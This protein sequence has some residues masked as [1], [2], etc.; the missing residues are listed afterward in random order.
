MRFELG[1][2]SFG[3]AGRDSEGNDV[4]QAMAVRNVL[5]QIRLAEEVGL[6]FFGVGEHHHEKVPVSSPTSVLNAAAAMTSK[7]TLSTAVSV[8]STDDPIRLYQQAATA[9]IVS[10]D[11]V[12]VIAGRGSSTASFPL[13]GYDLDDY[14]RL[15]ADKFGLLLEINAN[16]RVSWKSPF[17]PPLDD[18]LVVP[19]PDKP[20]KIW[21][22]SGGSPGSTMRAGSA[23][24][25][26]SYGIL[27]GAPE[28]WGQMASLYRKS[29][30][31]AGVNPEL[32]EISVASHGF[33]GRDGLAAKQRFHRHEIE[34]F[35][36][37]GR[38][39]PARWEDVEANYSPGGMVFAGE[40]HGR[41]SATDAS[42][43]W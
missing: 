21:L 15:Y 36:L 26:L 31:E 35:A 18:A 38:V 5:E 4:T 41:K 32:L 16:E 24:L 30:D 43:G 2:Y 23:G 11:R 34:S 39:I 9:A 17:R 22:G 3:V 8:L 14:D 25:P 37:A 10:G 1:V 40:P 20:L 12:E 6:D 27:N 13:F 28:R 33:V 42:L 29:A 19:R 7:I